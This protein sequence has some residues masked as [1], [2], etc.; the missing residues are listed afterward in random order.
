MWRLSAFLFLLFVIPAHAQV[1]ASNRGSETLC[2]LR[3]DVEFSNNGTPAAGVRVEL[4]QGL[5]SATPDQVALTN[6]SGSVEFDGLLPGHYR[7][8]VS[9]ERI[10]T[11]QTGDIHI[12]NDRMFES[13]LIV[14][15]TKTA[16][17]A[18]PAGSARS[19]DVLDLNVPKKAFKELARGDKEVERKHWK[20]AAEHFQKALSIDPRYPAALYNL[21]VAYYWLGKPDQQRSALQQAVRIDDRYVPALVGLAHLDFADRNL[22]ATRGLLDKAIA[23]DPT[24]VEALAL[25]VRVDFMQGQ[26]E[27]VIADAQ[28]VHG[29]PHQGYA[30][31]HYAAAAACQRLNRIPEMIAQLKLFLKEDPASPSAGHLRRIIAAAENHSR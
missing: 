19:V 3:V 6:S 24:N 27:Q 9:G 10:E 14:V 29:L 4:L 1:S 31:V 8:E 22:P 20:K 7:I 17:T 16:A 2:T 28:R 5:I 21:S 18:P 23:A 25:R 15:R 13:Q 12:T 26:Y 30:S 11:A